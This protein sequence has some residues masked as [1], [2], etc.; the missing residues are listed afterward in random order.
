VQVWCLSFS[1]SLL[2]HYE[3]ECDRYEKRALHSVLLTSNQNAN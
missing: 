3:W 2:L 1:C